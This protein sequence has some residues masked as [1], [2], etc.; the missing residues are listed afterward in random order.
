MRNFKLKQN[1]EQVQEA[2]DYALQVPQLSEANANQQIELDKY[3]SLTL[4][5]HTD[6]LIY[7]FK[8]GVPVGNGV[9]ITG[10]V[11]EGDIIGYID[12]NNNIILSGALAE[13]N[14]TI[15]YEMGDGTLV[16]IG[17]LSLAEPV[18]I[19]NLLPLSVDKSG[20]PYVGTNGE[21]GY[22]TKVKISTSSGDESAVTA[23]DSCAS[24]FIKL[25]EGKQ[26]QIRIKNVTLSDYTGGTI[27][28]IVF[29]KADKTLQKGVG[30]I[31]GA[32]NPK[33]TVSNGVYLFETKNWFTADALPVYFRF[34][35]EKITDETIVT[36]DQEIV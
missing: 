7:L 10:E 32:F 20:N 9:E 6:G 16:D 11:V 3:A 21:K 26:S 13:E 36:I 5:K 30:G 27:N 31:A 35:C 18:E 15:K 29:Y 28:N 2:I 14:Y 1:G 23:T 19:T 8:S 25:P 33:V 24:G 34:S 12:E 17:E 22:K 4:G